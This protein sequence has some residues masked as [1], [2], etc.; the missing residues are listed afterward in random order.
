[1]LHMLRHAAPSANVVEGLV[2][3]VR[4]VWHQGQQ[5]AVSDRASPIAQRERLRALFSALQ[6]FPEIV[7]RYQIVPQPLS[8]SLV[9]N[10]F[11][12]T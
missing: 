4:R 8:S 12:D 10:C 3:A 1:M 9:G 7:L 11:L 5:R 2:A 6:I